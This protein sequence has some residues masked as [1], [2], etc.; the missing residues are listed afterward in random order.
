MCCFNGDNDSGCSNFR[1]NVISG[2]GAQESSGA[3]QARTRFVGTCCCIVLWDDKKCDDECAG[4]FAGGA[5]AGFVLLLL[6]LLLL[7]R[8]QVRGRRKG[9]DNRKG[10]NDDVIK[11]GV[12]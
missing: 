11:G 9:F 6:L 10:D 8:L 4:L 7:S 3:D 2:N 1:T 12:R 5:A